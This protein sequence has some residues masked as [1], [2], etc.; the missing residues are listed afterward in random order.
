MISYFREYYSS[1]WNNDIMQLQ[2]HGW[3][4]CYSVA[5][6]MSNSLWPHGLQPA[7]LPCLSPSPGACSAPYPLSQW[8][9]PTIP[10][11]VI[12]FSSCLQSFPASW[13]FPMS[14]LFASGGQRIGIS[15]SASVLPMNIQDWF[16]LQP[17]RI[18]SN[19]LESSPTS[20]FKSINSS[21][22]SLLYGSALTSIHDYWTSMIT[23]H[24]FMTIG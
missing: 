14:W 4:C 6:S 7:R 5:H 22:L 3:A 18:F 24:P 15:A 21:V 17:F 20:Q 9:Q 8:C 1:I 23:G 10:S 2:Q 13:S 19:P 16:P 12:P 11:S